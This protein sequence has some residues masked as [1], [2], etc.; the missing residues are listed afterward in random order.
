[1]PQSTD[2]DRRELLKRAAALAAVTAGGAASGAAELAAEADA[3]TLHFF[4][5]G[6]KH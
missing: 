6:F 2:F 1:M 5:A 3:D 4:P